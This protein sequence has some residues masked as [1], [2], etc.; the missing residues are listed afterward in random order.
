[1]PVDRAARATVVSMVTAWRGARAIASP[2]VCT[3]RSK[4][5]AEKSCNTDAGC[6]CRY[7]YGTLESHFLTP[8]LVN[9]AVVATCGLTLGR[10]HCQALWWKCARP[11][12]AVTDRQP[13]A[14]NEIEEGRANPIRK[15]MRPRQVVQ[16]PIEG[17]RTIRTAPRRT[18]HARRRLNCA[19]CGIVPQPFAS[20][21]D[22]HEFKL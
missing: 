12:Q 9:V 13:F 1:V 6:Q 19:R 11:V 3:G 20:P 15:P 4:A 7:R 8:F 17:V 21:Q 18:R 10:G 16:V 5:D 2:L 22:G 14:I